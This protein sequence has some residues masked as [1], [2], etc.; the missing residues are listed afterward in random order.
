LHFYIFDKV[1]FPPLPFTGKHPPKN[2]QTGRLASFSSSKFGILILAGKLSDFHQI[3]RPVTTLFGFHHVF[4]M[5]SI[6]EIR[7]SK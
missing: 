1:S 5:I 6:L 4:W 2:S 7:K 3:E